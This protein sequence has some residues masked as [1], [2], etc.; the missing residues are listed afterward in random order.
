LRMLASR[1]QASS[2][3]S[4]LVVNMCSESNRQPG[5]NENARL[6]Y[7]TLLGA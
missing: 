6:T 5:R 2:M 1:R 3:G 7:W 4:G